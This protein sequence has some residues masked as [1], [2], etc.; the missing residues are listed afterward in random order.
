[1]QGYYYSGG[2]TALGQNVVT[3]TDHGVPVNIVFTETKEIV[4]I[5]E[6]LTINKNDITENSFEL[7][8]KN[9]NPEAYARKMLEPI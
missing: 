2:G 6:E 7:N 3:E 4:P 5:P 1:M 9:V 8:I